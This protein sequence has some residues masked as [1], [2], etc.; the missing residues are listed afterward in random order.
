MRV[1]RDR[2]PPSRLVEQMALGGPVEVG[3][4]GAL[5]D[6]GRATVGP[7]TVEQRQIGRALGVVCSLSAG[8]ADQAVKVVPMEPHGVHV[9]E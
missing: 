4:E 8:I 3:A 2:Y 9:V 5:I 7:K 1:G 6:D